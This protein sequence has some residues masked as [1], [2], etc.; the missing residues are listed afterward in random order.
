MSKI[1][2]QIEHTI[3]VPDALTGLYSADKPF[4]RRVT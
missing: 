1:G 4:K 2:S 3:K